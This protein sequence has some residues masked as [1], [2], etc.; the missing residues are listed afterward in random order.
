MQT[1]VEVLIMDRGY[2]KDEWRLI[3]DSDTELGPD[4][5]SG[6]TLRKA[7]GLVDAQPEASQRENRTT[8]SGSHKETDADVLAELGVSTIAEAD[9]TK[10]VI[11]NVERQRAEN[12]KQVQGDKNE[13]EEGVSGGE[14]D[15]RRIKQKLSVLHKEIAAVRAG[16]ED[17]AAEDGVKVEAEDIGT[18]G[19]DTAGTGGEGTSGAQESGAQGPSAAQG[20]RACTILY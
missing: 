8:T 17:E 7:G 1:L 19:V 2:S 12:E 10:R 20:E 16:L 14:L 13:D 18:V 5:K 15:K 4:E 6:S 9:V 3:E 11:E